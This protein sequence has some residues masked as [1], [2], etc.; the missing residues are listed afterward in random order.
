LSLLLHVCIRLA[1][2]NSN[3]SWVSRWYNRD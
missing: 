1:Q 2:W 3:F